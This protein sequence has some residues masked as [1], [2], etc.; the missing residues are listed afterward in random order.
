MPPRED[1][2]VD[3]NESDHKKRRTAANVV[4]KVLDDPGSFELTREDVNR[5]P[6][7]L[8]HSM[9]SSVATG[10]EGAPLELNLS[11]SLSNSQLSTFTLA[12][13]FTVALY[14]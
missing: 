11:K 7:S 2:P 1:S 6:G 3:D 4:V 14:R 13:A 5:H 8:L 9:L 10:E 12:A